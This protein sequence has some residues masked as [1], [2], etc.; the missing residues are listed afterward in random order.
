VKNAIITGIVAASVVIS[1]CGKGS[2]TNSDS[3]PTATAAPSSPAVAQSTNT[4]NPDPYPGSGGTFLGTPDR[5]L[6]DSGRIDFTAERFASFKIGSTTKAQVATL[7]GKPA[8]WLTDPQGS[9]Q[10]EYDYVE[11]GGVSDMRKI[12]YSI[13]TFNSNMVLSRI[14]YPDYDS[15]KQK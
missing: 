12:M 5:S 4:S 14:T 1:G 11:P 2:S 13:F 8:G 10:L 15:D 6:I 9:S 3:P 7:L